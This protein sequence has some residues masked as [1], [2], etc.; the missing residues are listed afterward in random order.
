MSGKESEK[1]WLRWLIAVV[2]VSLLVFVRILEL[3]EREKRIEERQKAWA[4][5]EETCK[6]IERQAEENQ[7]LVE[8]LYL[9]TQKRSR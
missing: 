5:L 1:N 3:N 8:K 6:K 4:K 9:K 2:V 7:R